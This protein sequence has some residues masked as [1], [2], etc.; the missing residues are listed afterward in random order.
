MRS[1]ERS[2]AEDWDRLKPLA[3]AVRAR[4][5]A[6]RITQIQLSELSGCGPAF[7]YAL[8]RGKPTLRI[9]KLLDVLQV[10]GLELVVAEGKHG[11]RVAEDLAGAEG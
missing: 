5:R 3:M 10:L 9:D 8:E 1:N 7:V 11:V 4:R 6:F 2:H